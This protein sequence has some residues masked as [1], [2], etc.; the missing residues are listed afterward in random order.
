MHHVQFLLKFG[1]LVKPIQPG[2]AA[3]KRRAGRKPWRRGGRWRVA[4][5][6]RVG[7]AR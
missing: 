6:I 3:S 2:G 4:I 7:A 1:P 5:M